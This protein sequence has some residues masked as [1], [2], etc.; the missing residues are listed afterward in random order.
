LEK[1]EGHKKGKKTYLLW[2]LQAFSLL[3]T[4]LGSFGILSICFGGVLP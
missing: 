3:D 1:N 4:V 2:L